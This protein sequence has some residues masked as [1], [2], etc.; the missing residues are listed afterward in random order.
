MEGHR[1]LGPSPRVQPSRSLRSIENRKPF[2]KEALK[3]SAGRTFEKRWNIIETR[4]NTIIRLLRHLSPSLA[5]LTTMYL[6]GSSSDFVSLP[7]SSSQISPVT[8]VKWAPRYSGGTVPDLHRL[9]YWA[10]APVIQYQLVVVNYTYSH[11]F[12]QC[13][14]E[15]KLIIFLP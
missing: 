10:C 5:G 14:S 11:L 3:P 15:R 1:W 7:I 6:T 8:L 12:C 13:F 9:L 2:F 4:I